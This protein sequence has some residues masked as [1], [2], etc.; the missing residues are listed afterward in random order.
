M[1]YYRSIHYVDYY[2]NG[3]KCCNV[4]HV[5][6]I[7]RDRVCTFWVHLKRDRFQKGQIVSYGVLSNGE[8]DQYLYRK[9]SEMIIK[10]PAV[11]EKL[12]FAED[13]IAGLTL[14]EIKGFHFQISPTKYCVALFDG[15]KAVEVIEDNVDDKKPFTGDTNE[16]LSEV[17][18]QA[19]EMKLYVDKWQQLRRMYPLVHPLKNG[20]EYLSISPKDFV[21]FTNE[22]QKLVHNSFLLHGFFNYRHIILGKYENRYYI[23]VPGTYHDREAVVAQMFGFEG[24][25][26]VEKKEG[27]IPAGTF[28]YYMTQVSI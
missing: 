28:G 20:K 13:C 14:S 6:L 27:A 5:K 17:E 18:T 24:F 21:I 2:E 19:S 1:S 23:G 8:K 4:G 15:N 22:Y 11:E 25:E 26:S 9:L 10:D 16:S 12:E 3:T 7:E